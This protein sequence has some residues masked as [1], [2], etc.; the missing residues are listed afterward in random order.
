VN[1]SG[2]LIQD[3]TVEI[4]REGAHLDRVRVPMSCSSEGAQGSIP[5]ELLASPGR[6]QGYDEVWGDAGISI[7]WTARS[8]TSR[9]EGEGRLETMPPR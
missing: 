4:E 1:Y 6:R 9:G 3:P 8:I 2:T 5:G 7:E